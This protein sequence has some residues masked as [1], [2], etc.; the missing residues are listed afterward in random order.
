[1]E[2]E[3]NKYISKIEKIEMK[4]E[5]RYIKS[6]TSPPIS[7][8]Q[9]NNNENIQNISNDSLYISYF[10]HRVINMYYEK[11]FIGKKIN[12]IFG[13]IST[14]IGGVVL[15]LIAILYIV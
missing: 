12:Q 10:I 3:I 13:N 2:L 5:K 9:N 7:N 11:E 8:N 1:M 4:E 15:I 14:L 6:H